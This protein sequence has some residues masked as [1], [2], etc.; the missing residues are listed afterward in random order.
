MFLK[1]R[2]FSLRFAGFDVLTVVPIMIRTSWDVT[3]YRLITDVSK[4]R[5]PSLFQVK[6]ADARKFYDC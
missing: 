6:Q 1:R 3:P 5:N 4:D 2:K